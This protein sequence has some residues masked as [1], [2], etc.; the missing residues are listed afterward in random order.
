MVKQSAW[1]Q[2]MLLALAGCAQTGLG[3]HGSVSANNFIQANYKAAENLQ[4]QLASRAAGNSTLLVA[5]LANIDALDRSST[6]GRLVSEQVSAR[7]TQGGYRMI[8]MKFQNSVYMARGQ[9]E[10]MLTRQVHELANA[11]S[12][13]A[14]IVGSYGTS[15]EY[16]LINLK[17]VEPATNQVLAVYDYSLPIDENVRMLLR[18]R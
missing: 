6:L 8:E 1:R 9:G 3:S 4:A 18:N 15:K 13:E 12:A 14:V 2:V 7:F 10:L 5:T 17:V 11:Y 16:V